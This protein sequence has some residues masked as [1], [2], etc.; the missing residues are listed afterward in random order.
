MSRGFA[1]RSERP[2][3][4]IGPVAPSS[5]GIATIM[6]VSTGS[7]PRS[8][9]PIARASGTRRVGGEIGHVEPRQHL[10]GGARV[11]VGG[12]ADEREAGE[13]DDGVDQRASVLDEELLDRRSRVEAGGEGGDDSEAA[14]FERGD[15]A[16][17]MAQLPA[18][19]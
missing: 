18:S 1:A 13:R 6:V 2:P 4:T 7:S 16:V 14:R 8:E 19:M 15:H 9:P 11:V 12:A 10:L 17:V 5:S 3:N